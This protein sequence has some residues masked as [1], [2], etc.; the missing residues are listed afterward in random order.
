MDAPADA[1]AT[2]V[3][4][5]PRSLLDLP[6]AWLSKLVSDHLDHR[7][8]S[9]LLMTSRTVCELVLGLINK[10]MLEYGVSVTCRRAAVW[11][12]WVMSL[13]VRLLAAVHLQ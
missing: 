9:C 4:C 11:V 13:G 5:T 3:M 12:G 8:R 10:F 6:R 7:A 1:T 2:V